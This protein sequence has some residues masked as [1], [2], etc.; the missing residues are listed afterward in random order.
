[1]ADARRPTNKQIVDLLE[2]ALR[3]M[4]DLADGQRRIAADLRRIKAVGID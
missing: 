4:S 2:Q 1:M 3:Q